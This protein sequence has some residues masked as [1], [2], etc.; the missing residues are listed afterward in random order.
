MS[1]Y[2]EWACEWKTFHNGEYDRMIAHHPLSQVPLTEAEARE[3]VQNMTAAG[4]PSRLVSRSVSEWTEEVAHPINHRP[5]PGP[6]HW[7]FK[8][9]QCDRLVS[10]HA[11]VWK[12]IFV[13]IKR[14]IKP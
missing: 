1:I 4:I 12:R 5:L 2:N 8:C 7:D 10:D 13:R 9:L 14:T 3:E 11:T 6:Q